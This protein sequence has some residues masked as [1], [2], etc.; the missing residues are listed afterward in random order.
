MS[1]KKIFTLLMLC[2]L[3]TCA[4]SNS[5][6]IS[7]TGSKQEIAISKKIDTK[8]LSGINLWIVNLYNEDRLLYAIVV[9]SVMALLGSVMAFGTDLVLKYFG[10]NVSKI[11]HSE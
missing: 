11:S 5:Y 10:I 4:Y 9:T 2:I 8:N 1:M 3:L 7:E 6:A